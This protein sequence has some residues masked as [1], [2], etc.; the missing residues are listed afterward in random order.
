MQ[1]G[2]IFESNGKTHKITKLKRRNILKE[3]V[4]GFSAEFI[5][6]TL[7]MLW[8]VALAAFFLFLVK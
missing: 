7:L 8:L 1:D 6:A 3:I 2:L 5:F 4:V